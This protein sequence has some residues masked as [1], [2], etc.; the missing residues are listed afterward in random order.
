[1]HTTKSHIYKNQVV[2]F[3]YA[4]A[5]LRHPPHLATSEG[6]RGKAR[7]HHSVCLWCLAKTFKPRR[8]K[9]IRH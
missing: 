5:P 6:T 8:S 7:L 1:M 3:I 9:N 4:G 2:V